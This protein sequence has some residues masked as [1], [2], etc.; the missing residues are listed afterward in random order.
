M[1][2]TKKKILYSL[3]E[4]KKETLE[5]DFIIGIDTKSS[6]FKLNIINK[7]RTKTSMSSI[8]FKSKIKKLL[9]KKFKLINKMNI[10]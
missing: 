5:K 2:I 10:N 1:G 4:A 8:N 9:I 3:K 6:I 7:R